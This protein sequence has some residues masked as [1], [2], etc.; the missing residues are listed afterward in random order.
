MQF[1]F[2]DTI[3]SQNSLVYEMHNAIVIAKCLCHHA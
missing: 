3:E 2:I 1:V